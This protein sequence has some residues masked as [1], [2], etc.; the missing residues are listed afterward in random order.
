LPAAES[1]GNVAGFILTELAPD[2]GHII[3]L[4]VLETTGAKGSLAAAGGGRGEA[5]REAETHGS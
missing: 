1:G 5:A 2:E 4:D 3:T